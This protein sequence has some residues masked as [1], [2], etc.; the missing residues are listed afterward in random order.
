M[1]SLWV[2]DGNSRFPKRTVLGQ[3][4]VDIDEFSDFELTVDDI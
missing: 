4:G 2:I 3:D 1:V